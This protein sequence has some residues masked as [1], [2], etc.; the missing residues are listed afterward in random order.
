[1]GWRGSGPLHFSNKEET[2][3]CCSRLV[4][5]LWT[6][7]QINSLRTAIN[8]AFQSEQQ[9]AEWGTPAVERIQKA[10]RSKILAYVLQLFQCINCLYFVSSVC[11]QVEARWPHG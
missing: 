2:L 8:L 4:N 9:M 6:A 7:L 1:M 5:V 11:W 3:I 10:S